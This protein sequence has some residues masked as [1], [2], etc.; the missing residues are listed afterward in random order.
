[1]LLSSSSY[2]EVNAAE[3]ASGMVACPR[4]NFSPSSFTIVDFT[5]IFG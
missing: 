3:V 4:M 1:M 2:K 5:A